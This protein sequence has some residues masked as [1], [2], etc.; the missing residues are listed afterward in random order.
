MVWHHDNML[1]MHLLDNNYSSRWIGSMVTDC[2]TLIKG[3]IFAYPSNVKDINGKIRLLYE[4]SF[5][6]Y[7]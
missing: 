7:F 6:F 1:I 3:G 4:A 2:R 5:C